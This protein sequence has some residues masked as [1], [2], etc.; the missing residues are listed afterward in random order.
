MADAKRPEL[1][2]TA[3]CETGRVKVELPNGKWLLSATRQADEQ[4]EGGRARPQPE[5]DEEG[6]NS[7]VSSSRGMDTDNDTRSYSKKPGKLVGI[8]SAKT[9][10]SANDDIA[11]YHMKLREVM[12]LSLNRTGLELLCA[13]LGLGTEF[14]GNKELERECQRIIDK[15]KRSRRPGME[16]LLRFLRSQCPNGDFPDLPPDKDPWWTDGKRLSIWMNPTQKKEV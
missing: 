14:V 7:A 4:T 8:A 2:P 11:P 10:M 9:K 1:V 6:Q 5:L 3:E 15:C 13:D 12:R 16:H